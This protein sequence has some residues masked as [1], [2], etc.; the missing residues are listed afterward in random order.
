MN[1][2]E[3]DSADLGQILEGFAWSRNL[4]DTFGD[5]S[6]VI[7]ALAPRLTDPF[8]ATRGQNGLRRH[9]QDAELE[10]SATD[11]WNQIFHY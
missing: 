8:H 5:S 2:L 9:V 11:I 10:R 1:R 3:T 4:G 7:G 6:R